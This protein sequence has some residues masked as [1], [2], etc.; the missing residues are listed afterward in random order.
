MAPL[1]PEVSKLLEQ[2]LSLSVE[3]QE[4]L[5]NSL[6]SNLGGELDEGPP[7]EGVDQAW[8]EEIKRRID[9]I[10]SGKTQM[11]PYEEVRRRLA[12]RLADTG[13]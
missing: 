8:A 9:D 7:E 3:E 12:A 6:I 11:I 1:T 4:A 2:A 10:D 13:K 5:A